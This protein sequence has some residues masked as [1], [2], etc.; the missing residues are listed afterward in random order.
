MKRTIRCGVFVFFCVCVFACSMQNPSYE[1]CDGGA[2]L[3]G[4]ADIGKSD[5]VPLPDSMPDSTGEAKIVYPDKDRDGHTTETDCNDDNEN[6]YPGADEVCN[7]VDDDCDG[8]I[9]KNDDNLIGVGK[10]CGN[11]IGEC[12]QGTLEC[13]NATLICD[14]PTLVLPQNELCDGKDNN[15]DGEID[16]DFKN[17]GTGNSLGD[18]C[19]SGQGACATSGWM[20]CNGSAT[21]LVCSAVAGVPSLEGPAGS[22][23]CYDGK[24]NDCDGLADLLDPNCVSC[25][26]DS[27]C[28]DQNACTSDSCVGGICQNSNLADDTPCSDGLFCS[29]IE[30]CKSGKCESG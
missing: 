1:Q 19:T 2:C 23:T 22:S 8:K 14:G 10:A 27:D 4:G 28:N 24:D 11:S 15:C 12:K 3:D 20:Q 29:G 18:T 30:A 5:S 26:K 9:D 6:I 25:S 17:L 21:K 13:T 16:E 7:G